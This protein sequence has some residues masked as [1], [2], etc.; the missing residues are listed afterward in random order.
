MVNEFPFYFSDDEGG[1]D[2]VHM[3][4]ANDDEGGD[5]EDD[6]EDPNFVGP[7][8]YHITAI[9]DHRLCGGGMVKKG[10]YGIFEYLTVFR[11]YD[12]R[13]WLK[14]VAFADRDGY[15]SYSSIFTDYCD[16]NGIV[17]EE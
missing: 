6:S 12:E 8:E 14:E 15:G 17:Y 10:S 1:G 7:G 3:P 5:D 2:N 16:A 9:L 11:D 4:L 13:V